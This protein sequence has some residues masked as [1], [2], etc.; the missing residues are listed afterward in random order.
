MKTFQVMTTNGDSAYP[1]TV[2][3]HDEKRAIFAHN[4]LYAMADKGVEF[5][6]RFNLEV[7][8]EHFCIYD[9][10]GHTFQPYLD[11]EW[12]GSKEKN[13]AVRESVLEANAKR[14]EAKGIEFDKYFE[15]KLMDQYTVIGH[16]P[17]NEQALSPVWFA[18]ETWDFDKASEIAN[19][20]RFGL[21]PDI[22]CYLKNDRGDVNTFLPLGV[23]VCNMDG[24]VYVDTKKPN[25]ALKSS[26][27]KA[28]LT[29]TDEDLA[30][31]TTNEEQS[32]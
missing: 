17:E 10:D 21:N 26:E 18:P 32:L 2:P 5:S 27:I 22:T 7:I 28:D 29:L 3:I 1:L 30:G 4:V 23:S 16:S 14:S 20:I 24:D 31:L 11:S 25:W 8:K 19:F 15:R 12:D 9:S 13:L 6:A